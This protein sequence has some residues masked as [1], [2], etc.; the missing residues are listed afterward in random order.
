MRNHT[1]K[2][3]F[4]LLVL[5]I[6]FASSNMFNISATEKT[7]N[8]DL[9][10]Q[11]FQNISE[12]T[13]LIISQTEEFRAYLTIGTPHYANGAVKAEVIFLNNTGRNVVPATINLTIYD[14]N[15]V[16]WHQAAKGDFTLGEKNVW[17][18]TK[19]ISGSP[20][21]GMYTAH[22]QATY[23]NY[24]TTAQTV[25]FRITTGG[26]FRVVLNCVDT[27]PAA[28]LLGCTVYIMDEGEAPVEATCTNWLDTN[29]DGVQNPGEVLFKF[30]KLTQPQTN[31]SESFTLYVPGDHPIGP[32]PVRTDCEYLTSD[33][34]NSAAAD[35]VIITLGQS[36]LTGFVPAPTPPP[37]AARL[38][39]LIR[40]PLFIAILVII[41]LGALLIG[42]LIT[43]KAP[44]YYMSPM[45]VDPW[46]GKKP[47][48]HFY[49]RPPPR[50][51]A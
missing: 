32:F 18:E 25:Y 6:C 31:I 21:T 44:R 40:S 45:K 39:E 12:D 2:F 8:A 34:P 51:N 10:V 28:S 3:F 23:L 36:T 50:K 11:F 47:P 13:D 14:P 37:L 33:H 29:N 27:V 43:G 15:D 22:L 30:S 24:T 19:S 9:D 49:E 5:P 4:F 16:V 42:M 20:T 1:I 46:D 48:E 38:P 26:P 7:E 35:T 17:T 41:I